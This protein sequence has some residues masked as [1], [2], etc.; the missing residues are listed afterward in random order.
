M[1]KCDCKK[2]TCTIESHCGCMFPKEQEP[3]CTC[4]KIDQDQPCKQLYHGKHHDNDITEKPQIIEDPLGP[5][6]QDDDVLHPLS[7]AKLS[8]IPKIPNMPTPV[9]DPFLPGSDL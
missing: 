9:G 7:K 4:N 1:H 6:G 8:K 3:S 5:I 2:C